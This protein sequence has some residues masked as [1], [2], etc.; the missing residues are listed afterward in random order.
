MR[1]LALTRPRAGEWERSY[2]ALQDEAQRALT[3][4]SR[5]RSAAAAEGEARREIDEEEP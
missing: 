3:E 1:R 2:K 4:L 5:A